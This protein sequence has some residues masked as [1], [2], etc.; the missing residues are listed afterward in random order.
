MSILA[1]L[2]GFLVLFLLYQLAE[3]G[4]Q[5]VLDFPGR[6]YTFFLLFLLVIPAA[7]LVARWQGA[8][9]LSAYGM[10]LHRGW[11]Q[12]YVLGLL[13][14]TSVQA[15]LEFVGIWLGIRRVSNLR[16]SFR[17][18][19]LGIGWILFSNF[20]A[21][22]SEDLITRGYVWR[23]MQQAPLEIFLLISALLYTLNHMIRLL[24]RP[25]TD[26]YHLP[27]LGLTLAY[28][29][30]QTG[31]LWLVIGLHQSGNVVYALMQQ[32]MDITNT[33]DTNKRIG[34]GILSELILWLVVIV[35]IPLAPPA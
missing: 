23:F 18:I 10:G 19:I 15:T 8:P 4:A 25:I 32:M 7:D 35:A 28:A 17:G 6:P 9:G 24:T 2:T 11:W 1:I 21:A 14:G 29:L 30:Y 22:A 5:G 31:S 16:I 34:F 33:T 3:A 26:W 20:P 13:L 27:F 12:N